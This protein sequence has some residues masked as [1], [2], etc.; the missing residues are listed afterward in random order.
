MKLFARTCAALS[1][2][3]L[4]IGIVLV[5]SGCQGNN[6]TPTIV[7]NTSPLPSPNLTNTLPSPP[8]SNPLS[9][10]TS[11]PFTA[12]VNPILANPSPPT[13]PAPYATRAPSDGDWQT[14]RELRP[15]RPDT[16][17]LGTPTAQTSATSGNST[18]SSFNESDL[19]IHV[20]PQA[21]QHQPLRILL[22]LHGM[23]ARGDA[24]A[25]SLINTT[26]ST[27][28]VVVAPTMPYRDYMN[29]TQ[30]MEDDL[31]ISHM[32][33]RLLNSL[34][35]RLNLKLR[36]HILVYGFSR[37]AQLA[38]RFALIHPERIESV[39]T[40][41]GG[42]Y[43]LPLATG[44]DKTPMLFPFGIGDL[45]KHQGHPLDWE[46]YKR[47]SFWVAVGERDTQPTDVPRAF[48]PFLGKT[49]VERAAAFAKSLSAL[50]IDAHLVYFPNTGHEV[51]VEMRKSALQFLRDD[52]IAD[53]WD[54]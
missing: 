28:W 44:N 47:I 48:D 39:V 18:V 8:S 43:T 29:L 13:T 17:A 23:G 27:N 11:T 5:L 7:A 3:V 25:Q 31:K 32:L 40:I 16:T 42:S 20:P 4:V 37:G 49:R 2:A 22:V 12:Q 1:S 53:H 36:Q 15:S 24:F 46:S 30:L 19:Y 45:E 21:A 33:D 26:D 14:A 38:E 6:P 52:E 34:P 51:T 9:S 41:S 50:G 35:S 54:D 10:L